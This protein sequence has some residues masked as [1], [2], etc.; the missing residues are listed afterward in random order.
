MAS[1]GSSNA[2]AG[3]TAF[4]EV[5]SKR[6]ATA[7]KS[8]VSTGRAS[9]SKAASAPVEI[10]FKELPNPFQTAEPPYIWI[11]HPQQKEMLSGPTYV[12]R[13]GVGG[14]E[15]V[16]LSIDKGNWLPCRLTSGYWWFDWHAI[17]PGKHTLVA[18]MRTPEGTWY[19]TPPRSCDY[20]P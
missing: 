19:K 2:F 8:V 11:D 3:S 10:L 17:T 14:A 20:R 6:K 7:R 15:T 5:S 12:I 18:R 16:E 13:L 9:V 4:S 1:N